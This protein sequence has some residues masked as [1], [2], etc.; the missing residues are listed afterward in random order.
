VRKQLEANGEKE[1][2]LTLSSLLSSTMM[3]QSI[4]HRLAE[5]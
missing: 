1:D 3:R 4:A 2:K 5:M